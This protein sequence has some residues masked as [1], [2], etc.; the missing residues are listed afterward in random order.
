MYSVHCAV[1]G[2]VVHSFHPIGKASNN[3]INVKRN[4][5]V[6][7]VRVVDRRLISDVSSKMID[8]S[9]P[10]LLG[11]IGSRRFSLEGLDFH[12]SDDCSPLS[13][14]MLPAV[15]AEFLINWIRV[16]DTATVTAR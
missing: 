7:S 16:S 14:G 2:P 11:S 8:Y 4:K 5:S 13:A 3:T 1:S 15:L 12:F 10:P 6:P 9:T